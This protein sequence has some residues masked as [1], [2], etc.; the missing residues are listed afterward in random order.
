M[1]QIRDSCEPE[2]T[3]TVLYQ[4][5]GYSGSYSDIDDTERFSDAIDLTMH[6]GAQIDFKFTIS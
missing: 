6:T 2:I 5:N 1:P 4:T 3:D